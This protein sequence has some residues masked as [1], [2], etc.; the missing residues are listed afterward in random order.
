VA[1][2]FLG[3][4]TCLI[5]NK[6]QC[7]LWVKSRHLVMR[8]GCPLPAVTA[9]TGFFGMNFNWLTVRE[10]RSLP[11]P[12]RA[13]APSRRRPHHR[14]ALA[15]RHH[16]F[17][18][19]TARRAGLRQPRLARHCRAGDTPAPRALTSL[20][21]VESRASELQIYFKS[22]RFASRSA[23]MFIFLYLGSSVTSAPTQSGI[24]K[25]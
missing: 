9:L 2:A 23:S 8:Q 15:P 17:P 21:G 22:L 16:P 11:H 19:V 13:A 12:R 25:S 7:R 14:L 18:S 10:R 6:A 4:D 20:A 24:C 1:I 3:A 5:T